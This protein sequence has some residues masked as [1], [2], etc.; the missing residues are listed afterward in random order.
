MNTVFNFYH[1]VEVSAG[2]IE[3]FGLIG[4]LLFG[5]LIFSISIFLNDELG[6]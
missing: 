5:Y 6:K 4:L 1:S 2:S 3:N